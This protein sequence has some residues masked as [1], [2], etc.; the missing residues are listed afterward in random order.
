MK[1]SIKLVPLVLMAF[2]FTQINAQD[3]SKV[4]NGS[5]ETIEGK[6]KGLGYLTGENVPNW[7]T[8]RDCPPVD[9]FTSS[10]KKEEVQVPANAYGTSDTQEGDNYIGMLVYSEREENPRMYIQSKLTKTLIAGKSYCVRMH[11]SMADLSKYAINNLGMHLSAAKVKLATIEEGVV[12]QVLKAN[13]AIITEM[14]LWTPICA[15]FEATG[16]EKYITIGNFAKQEDVLSQKVRRPREYT[17]QQ[18]RGAYYYFDDISVIASNHLDEPCICEEEEK[19]SNDRL[20]V[21][22]TLNTSENM[23][24]A[25]AKIIEHNKVFFTAGRYALDEDHKYKLGKVVYLMQENVSITLVVEGHSDE[26][27]SSMYSFDVSEKRANA[28]RTFL[29]SKGIDGGRLSISAVGSIN[30]DAGG[31]TTQAKAQ[32]RRVQ[33]IATE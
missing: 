21:V 25:P 10:A 31:G 1:S 23:D 4:S 3:F 22:H 33:F 11:V 20:Q 16:A 18:V 6:V 8:P 14:G 30:P 29:I 5:F 19:N 2:A 13:N 32:N 24:I 9:I 15:E 28:V 26:S 12:P 27:E 17:Q 7:E